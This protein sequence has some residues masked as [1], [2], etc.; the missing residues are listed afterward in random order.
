MSSN[1]RYIK[2]INGHWHYVR[3]VPARYQ[4]VDPRQYSR[5]SMKTRSV[6]VARHIRDRLAEADDL[7]WAS[8][9]LEAINEVVAGGGDLIKFRYD[10]Q[11]VLA[12]EGH[13]VVARNAMAARC[14]NIQALTASLETLAYGHYRRLE[15]THQAKER[16]AVYGIR[17]KKAFAQYLEEISFDDT[18]PKSPNQLKAWT[19]GKTTSLNYFLRACGNKKMGDITRDDALEYRNWWR[20]R[21]E[22]GMSPNTAN[23]HIGFIRD[24]YTQWFEHHGIRD[25][26]NPFEKIHFTDIRRAKRPRY[27]D[28]WVRTKLIVP[29]V[30]PGAQPEL[31]LVMYTL[32]ET[33]CRLSEICNLEEDDIVLD[34]ATPHIKIRPKRNRTIKSD[35]AARDIPLVGLA[36][37]SLKRAPEGFPAFRD[38]GDKLSQNLLRAMREHG[39]CPT[40]QHVLHSFRHSFE[41]RMLEAGIDADLRRRLMGHKSLRAEYG[42][43]G[44]M[45][46][47]AQ[48]LRRISHPDTDEVVNSLP[49]LRFGK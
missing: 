45:A 1:N 24:L 42:E 48:Q 41:D 33:G 17:V 7:Y 4:G 40:P 43:G 16:E 5:R 8:L 15:T 30:L 32:L 14:E 36:L 25:Q 44:S 34:A 28:E 47:R 26:I 13:R 46:F 3:R 10:R 22:K 49:S 19:G 38:N 6:A 20:N 21:I 35:Q 31:V 12:L 18:H 9:S 27:S 11:C 23:R 29:N 2:Q 37:E 39:L